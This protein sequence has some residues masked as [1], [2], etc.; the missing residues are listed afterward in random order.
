MDPGS[1]PGQAL[2]QVRNDPLPTGERSPAKA[3]VQMA[4]RCLAWTPAFAGERQRPCLKG[5][6]VK[7]VQG[8]EREKPR[9]TPNPDRP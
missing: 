8:D 5:V 6:N 4:Q 1:G 7:Q 2:K 9:R 3:G